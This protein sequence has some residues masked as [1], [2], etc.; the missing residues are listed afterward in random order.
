MKVSGVV[1]SDASRRTPTGSTSWAW[2]CTP[3]TPLIPSRRR[4]STRG[5]STCGRARRYCVSAG[6]PPTRAVCRSNGP[7][8]DTAE[9]PPRSR[10]ATR[11][12]SA[13]CSSSRRDRTDR[14]DEVVEC[15][16]PGRPWPC[17]PTGAVPPH[18]RN[19][20]T[21]RTPPSPRRPRAP[22]RPGCPRRDHRC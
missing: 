2:C 5:C 14:S 8:T 11:V 1:A 18:R 22:R 7:T 15:G 3:C 4:Q 21:P 19:T 9:M 10:C 16:M 13:I 12:T 20:T 6:A 17:H